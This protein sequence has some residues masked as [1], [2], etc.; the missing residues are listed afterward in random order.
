[1]FASISACSQMSMNEDTSD[2]MEKLANPAHKKCIVDGYQIRTLYE[3]GVPIAAKCI[4][5][6]TGK[7][8]EVWDYF[9]GDCKLP[10]IEN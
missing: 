8:C 9:R 3:N 2:D 1:M 5:P 10:Q 7:E 6:S 4:D